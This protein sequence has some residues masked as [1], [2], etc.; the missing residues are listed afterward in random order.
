MVSKTN[1]IK[2]SSRTEL[3]QSP[4]SELEQFAEA[5]NDAIRIINNDFTIRYINHAFAEMAGIDQNYAIGKKCW[6]VFP[7]HL[8][9]TQ[10]CR[11]Y[12]VINGEQQVKLEIERQ[13]Y[14]GTPIPCI[15]TTLP[16]RDDNGNISGIIEQFRDITEI[17][18]KDKEIKETEDRYQAIVGLTTQAG[19]AIVLLQD[20]NGKEGIQVFIND[21]WPKITG[22]SREELLG[23]SFFDLLNPLDRKS[24]LSRH[25]LKMSGQIVPGLYELNIIRKDSML[26]PVELTGGYTNYQGQLTNIVYIRDISERKQAE[27][28]L[29]KEKNRYA[30][31]FENAPIPIAEMDLSKRRKFIDSLKRQGITDL[32]DYFMNNPDKFAKYLSL[33]D[34]MVVNK[35][36][37]QLW[38]MNN[39]NKLPVFTN[40]QEMIESLKNH[41][42]EYRTTI[43]HNMDIINGIKP[44]PLDT[45]LITFEGKQKKYIRA[46]YFIAP[47]ELNTYHV[48]WAA[49]DITDRVEAENKLKEYQNHLEEIIKERSK[50]LVNAE[51]ETRKAFE[52]EKTLRRSLQKQIDERTQFTRALVHELKTPITPLLACSESLMST[53]LDETQ[54][55]LVNNIHTGGKNLAS[56]VDELLDLAKGEVGL[57]NL[58]YHTVNPKSLLNEV[59]QY[60]SPIAASNGLVLKLEAPVKL[61]SIR[62]DRGRIQQV[63]SNLIDNA[64]KYSPANGCITLRACF[65]NSWLQIEVQDTGIGISEEKQKNLFQPYKRFNADRPQVSGLGLGL[66]L[67]KTLVE[68]HG[69]SITF[70][71]R[72]GIGSSFTINL[73]VKQTLS[74]AKH[75]NCDNRG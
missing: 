39:V 56:R 75:E 24:S 50:Q 64:I 53:S 19:E 73:P 5:S 32:V 30:F 23:T 59:I 65:D 44:A 1:N 26:I 37:K 12:C 43:I 27:E 49:V 40:P 58:K 71:S 60:F 66:S 61:P 10:E 17:R 69:G 9:H 7:S 29:K 15:V 36:W 35:T 22:Y 33:I 51:A 62:I 38:G 3:N 8:C 34:H 13:K 2:K 57:L 48:I 74:E 63:L 31:L 72:K 42:E 20:I 46:F 45:S 41:P 47:Q 25:R 16:L 11:A 28:I 4:R 54:R 52:K 18:H 14:D 6:E 55:S 21:E 70:W 68:L 67:A